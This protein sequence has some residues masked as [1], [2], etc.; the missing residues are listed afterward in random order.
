[1]IFTD[2]KNNVTYVTRDEGGAFTKLGPLPFSPDQLM[3]HPTKEDWVLAYDFTKSQVL[4][5][6]TFTLLCP[7]VLT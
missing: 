1:M 7:F 5:K 2:I 4:L 6:A 3:F